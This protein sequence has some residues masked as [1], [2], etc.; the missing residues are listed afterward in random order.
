[1]EKRSVHIT[2]ESRSGHAPRSFFLGALVMCAAIA[3]PI[4]ALSQN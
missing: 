1:M 4:P 2:R 3:Y